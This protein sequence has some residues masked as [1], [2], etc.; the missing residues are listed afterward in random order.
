MLLFS[1]KLQD[2]IKQNKIMVANL[3]NRHKQVTKYTYF[4]QDLLQ[5]EASSRNVLKMGIR[6][7]SSTDKYVVPMKFDIICLSETYLDSNTLLDDDDLEISGY[8]LV[9]SDHPSNTKRGGVCL[10]YK[11]SYL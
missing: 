8:T 3:V 9:Y 7:C 4:N 5:Y 10:Y 11:N 1:P 6:I 2:R